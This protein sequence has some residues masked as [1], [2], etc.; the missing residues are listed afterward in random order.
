MMTC[1]VDVKHRV[2]ADTMPDEALGATWI[3]RINVPKEHRGKRLGSAMLRRL[4]DVADAE[5][6][7]LVLTPL[8]SGGLSGPRLIAWY[9]RYGFNW[10][11]PGKPGIMIRR[12]R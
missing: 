11:T 2:I 5:G 4:C 8:S 1:Y 10:M 6:L 7:S 9:K 3:N 12:P